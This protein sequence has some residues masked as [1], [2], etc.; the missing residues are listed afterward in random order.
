MEKTVN[1][2]KIFIEELKG[3]P[4]EVMPNLLEIVRLFKNS[5]LQNRKDNMTLQEE[6]DQWDKLSDEAL[7]EFE[8]R[9]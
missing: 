7:I 6:F 1:Y 4:E 2:Q 3:L 5:V 9:I 8:K